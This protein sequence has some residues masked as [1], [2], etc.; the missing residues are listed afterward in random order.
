MKKL[1]LSAFAPACTTTHA[2]FARGIAP[3]AAEGQEKQKLSRASLGACCSFEAACLP[4]SAEGA[5][6]LLVID[7]PTGSPARHCGPWTAA[8]LKAFKTLLWL[9]AYAIQMSII[10]LPCRTRFPSLRSWSQRWCLAMLPSCW[11]FDP[12]SRPTCAK[13]SCAIY[14]PTLLYKLPL[15]RADTLSSSRPLSQN[16]AFHCLLISMKRTSN[17]NCVLSRNITC[18]LSRLQSCQCETV[19]TRSK[20][21]RLI[22][23]SMLSTQRRL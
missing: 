16:L 21:Q 3:S 2:H 20:L 22:G 12:P 10:M 6:V 7:L 11:I 13:T 4:A 23:S 19:Y 5:S 8:S 9:W 15:G 17:E 18:M 1:I 14:L